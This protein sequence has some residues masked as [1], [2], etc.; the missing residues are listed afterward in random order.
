MR[1]ES[2]GGWDVDGEDEEGEKADGENE[3][4]GLESCCCS[5]RARRRVE[6]WTIA[7]NSGR[8]RS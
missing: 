4:D 7:L 1:S 3:G 8:K 5:S 2:G 6:Y